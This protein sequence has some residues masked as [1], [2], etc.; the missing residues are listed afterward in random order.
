MGVL[1]VDAVELMEN[2][3]LRKPAVEEHGRADR[4]RSQGEALANSPGR[5][6][7]TN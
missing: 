3:T 4:G 1:V 2:G 6:W 7:G 5:A